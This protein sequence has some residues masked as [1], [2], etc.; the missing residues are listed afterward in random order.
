MEFII[1]NATT[2]FPI[3]I[4]EGMSGKSLYSQ[5][6]NVFNTLLLKGIEEDE[7]AR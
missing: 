2:P 1:V 4:G 6:P 5:L 7:E 3:F